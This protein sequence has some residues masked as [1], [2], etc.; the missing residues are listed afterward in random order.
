MKS[1][2]E[3]SRYHHGFGSCDQL[4]SHHV[5]FPMLLHGGVVAVFDVTDDES[6]SQ[7]WRLNTFAKF[8]CSKNSAVIK[9]LLS[10]TLISFFPSLIPI[11]RL[12]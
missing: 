1:I 3:K 7:T 6:N 9:F 8:E 11:P 5:S 4:F 12:L 10:L 2:K